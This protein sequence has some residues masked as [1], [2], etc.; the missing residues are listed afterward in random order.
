LILIQI[1][2]SLMILNLKMVELTDNLNKNFLFLFQPY[3]NKSSLYCLLINKIYSFSVQM[4]SLMISLQSNVSLSI[5][6]SMTL[7]KS[8]SI[9]ILLQ[10]KNKKIMPY[11]HLFKVVM[12]LFGSQLMILSKNMSF[13]VIILNL[14]ANLI[15]S[16]LLLLSWKKLPSY[17]LLLFSPKF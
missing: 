10:K 1:L 16:F 12:S 14:S 7:K 5:L 17:L 13:Y 3:I 8:L 11:I 9:I 15:I 2:Q 4:F 6:P